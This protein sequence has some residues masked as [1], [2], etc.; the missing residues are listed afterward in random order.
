MV[1]TTLNSLKYFSTCNVAHSR[2]RQRVEGPPA[3]TRRGYLGP[4]VAGP[5]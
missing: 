2:E 1:Q 5:C 4:V 3:A